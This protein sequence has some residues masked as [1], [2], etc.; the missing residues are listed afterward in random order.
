MTSTADRLR[1][2][3]EASTPGPFTVNRYENG[4]GRMFVDT[5][6]VADFYGDGPG[7]RELF[8]AL[9]EIAPALVEWAAAW[10]E[11]NVNYD[12]LISRS[13]SSLRLNA[14]NDLLAAI[15][16]ATQRKE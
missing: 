10:S 6:L 2:L 12:P 14:Y 1:A 11:V 13:I 8:V 16:R 3:V 15:D 9:R 4:G 7:N 5:N